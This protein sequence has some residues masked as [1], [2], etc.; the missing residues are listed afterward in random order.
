MSRAGLF[1]KRI[2]EDLRTLLDQKGYDV[3][4]ENPWRAFAGQGPIV[5]LSTQ[6]LDLRQTPYERQHQFPR[7]GRHA[8]QRLDGRFDVPIVLP[9][10]FSRLHCPSLYILW[11]ETA[12]L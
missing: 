2:T 6:A 5:R 4:V 8:T 3:S 7:C 12:D 9:I 11:R 10:S 1:E